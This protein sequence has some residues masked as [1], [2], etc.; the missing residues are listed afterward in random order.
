MNHAVTIG[1][2][3]T[4]IVIGV[5]AVG[6]VGFFVWLLSIFANAFKD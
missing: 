5:A 4:I 3:V 1:D 6:V 2:M